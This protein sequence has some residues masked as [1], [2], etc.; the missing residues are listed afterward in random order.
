MDADSQ[1]LLRVVSVNSIHSP[2]I[3]V[4]Y[5]LDNFGIGSDQEQWLIIDPVDKWRVNFIEEMEVVLMG[6]EEKKAKAT[7]AKKV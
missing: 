4:P 1:P 2:V 7:K 3:A 6:K 5:D